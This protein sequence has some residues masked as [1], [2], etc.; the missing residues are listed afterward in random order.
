MCKYCVQLSDVFSVEA[1]AYGVRTIL[2]ALTIVQMK[3]MSGMFGGLAV[4]KHTNNYS[5]SRQVQDKHTGS[6][7]VKDIRK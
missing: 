1:L 3:N 6:T 5:V 7:V 2:R 4:M